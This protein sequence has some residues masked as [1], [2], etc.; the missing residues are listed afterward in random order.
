M[1]ER[2]RSSHVRQFLIL[3]GL[4]AAPSLALAQTPVVTL[5]G[6]VRDTSGAPVVWARVSTAGLL[7]ISDTA[8]R[9]MLTGLPTGALTVAVRRLGFHPR[10]T[11][12]HL[13]SGRTDSLLV[14]LAF[15]PVELPEVTAEADAVL[16]ARLA[17]FYR[18]RQGNG[19][20]DF[21]DRTQIEARRVSRLSDLLRRLPGVRIMIDRSGR[22]YLRLT[23]TSGGRDCPP[24]YWIDGVRAAFM[25]VDD[26]PISD[27][28]ALELYHGPAGVPPEYN[29]RLGSPGCG[30]IVIWTR[31]PG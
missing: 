30:T 15:L 14:V 22:Q 27:V 20:G 2:L 8:G 19:A 21:F 6:V 29:N 7:A 1:W 31:V 4:T 11:A 9:F 26:F 23:R 5:V 24:D 13:V 10:D 17:E 16:R 28:E 12:L 25:N 3:A 18:H